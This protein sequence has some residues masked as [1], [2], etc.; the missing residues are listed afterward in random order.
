[1]SGRLNDLEQ[2]IIRIMSNRVIA[3]W[4]DI[5]SDVDDRF[6]KQYSGSGFDV[7]LSRSLKRLVERKILW[8]KKGRSGY[9]ISGKGSVLADKLV[10][11]LGVEDVYRDEVLAFSGVLQ[12]LRDD[13]I[14]WAESDSVEE[15]F[16]VFRESVLSLDVRRFVEEKRLYDMII[17]SDEDPLSL[18]SLIDSS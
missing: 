2:E 18:A 4:T 5:K 16:R 10:A 17:D 14:I 6:K 1:M 9:V 7:V 13:A 3:R 15:Y 8:R 12:R 11:G